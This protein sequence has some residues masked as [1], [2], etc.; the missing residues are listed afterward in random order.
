MS[1]LTFST[2]ELETIVH[3]Q[4]LLISP[5]EHV[6]VDDWRRDVNRLLLPLV[7]ADSAGFLLPGVGGMAMF[8]EE[9]DAK[10]LAVFPESVPPPTRDGSPIWTRMLELR[11][12]TLKEAYHGDITPYNRSAYYNEYAAANKACETLSVAIPL[13][14]PGPDAA[15]SLHFWHNRLRATRE[16][17][18]REV[19]ILRVLLP[20]FRAGVEAQLRFAAHRHD[21]VQALDRLGHAV[22]VFDRLGRPVHQTRALTELLAADVENAAL[23]LAMRR[24]AFALC[25]APATANLASQPPAQRFATATAK[26]RMHATAY[27]GPV[28]ELMVLVSL[29]RRTPRPASLKDL[30]ETLGLT[31]AESR[32]A[33]CLTSGCDNAALARTLGISPHTARRHTERVLQKLGARSRAEVA[34]KLCF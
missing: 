10:Q 28:G 2:S 26:Y 30:R 33:L 16:F 34:S 21:L 6:R 1:T 13:G 7:G 24:A 17:G 27:R 25:G 22:M 3:A 15:A 18:E 14:A 12:C 11:A 5:L 31:T 29:D 9:H 23:T 4:R 32:V 19:T 8:S 20:A